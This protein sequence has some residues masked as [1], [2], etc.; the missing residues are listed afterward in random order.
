VGCIY[1]FALKDLLE[2]T[3]F[4]VPFTVPNPENFFENIRNLNLDKV[5]IFKSKSKITKYYFDIR[6][7]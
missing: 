1:V 4:S 2:F 5:I 6:N 3:R 7:L